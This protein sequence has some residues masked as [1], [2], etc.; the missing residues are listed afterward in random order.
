MY[1]GSSLLARIDLILR[2]IRADNVEQDCSG[3]PCKSLFGPFRLKDTGCCQKVR[4]DKGSSAY[5]E[6]S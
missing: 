5:P 6:I 1:E 3:S 2:E 4:K